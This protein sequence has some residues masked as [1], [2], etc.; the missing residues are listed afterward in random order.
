MKRKFKSFWVGLI[1]LTLVF[2]PVLVAA[3]MP[4]A[5]TYLQAQTQDAW[6]TMA[7]AAASQS[8]IPTSHLASVSGTLATDYAKTILALAAVGE[9]P[10][11]FGSV[12]YVAQLKTYH[13][14]NQM[15]SAS[16]LNDDMW[17]I[18]ALASVGEVNS[19]EAADAKN[20]ILAHQ[21]PDGGFGYAASG[22][23]SDTNDTA[24]AIMALVEEGLNP[25]DSVITNALAYIQTAQN[26]DGG[27]GY[28]VGSASDSGSD[29]WVISALAKVNIDPTTWDQGGNNPLTHLQSLQD[30][31]GGF[32]WV[33][34]GTSE[35][36]NKAMTAFAVIALSG[37]SYPV[38]Y[39]QGEQPTPGTYHL[40]IEGQ[41]NT[42]CDTQVT[43]VTALEVVE[44]AAEI[45]DYTY[46]IT[47]ESYGPY[48]RAINDEAA[49]DLVG[50]L[51]FVNNVS[52]PIGAANYNLSE[53]DEV[54]WYY[55]EWGW[56]PT[57]I[58]A[59]PAEI[60]PGQTVAVTAEYFNGTDWL[61]LPNAQ[62]KIN[63]EEKIADALGHLSLV[64]NNNGIY[65]IYVDTIGFVRSEKVTVTVGDT[66]SQ[67]VGLQ[68][69][70]DQSESGN[71][72]GEAIA[73]VVTPSQLNFGTLKP[74]E[75]AS[76]EVTLNNGGTVG[77][78]VDAEVTGDAVFISG[79]KINDNSYSEYSEI[80]VPTE[81]KTA[82]VSLTV[83]GSYLASGIKTGELIFWATSQ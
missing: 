61:P 44:N 68:V 53:G 49:H 6:T 15:G 41:A 42:I 64:I 70:I 28:E 1:M 34:E 36:N 24:A 30:D 58:N 22:N 60:D 72:G 5:V 67:Q 77:L 3:G 73:L 63:A 80:L 35:W 69:E 52:P 45:C 32:W 9:N 62:L 26:S 12:D 50:W 23:N 16:L 81:S 29:S 74:G 82:N 25:S 21:N 38:G 51:Y 46:T 19:A 57:R 18:L 2:Q 76:Q 55:G 65:Q 71:I 17:A 4:E 78:L 8:S 14:N 59:S 79:I 20:F 10:A 11:T 48:L 56:N 75:S 83:P 66:I 7:L 39:Y 40:R 27:I 47:Q 43:G 33:E 54:L 37:K 31:D 13:N